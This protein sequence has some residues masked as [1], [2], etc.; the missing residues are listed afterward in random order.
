[1]SV[2]AGG[3]FVVAFAVGLAGMRLD[4]NGWRGAVCVVMSAL[5]AIVAAHTFIQ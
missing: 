4:P 5:L 3:I 1:M 2:V